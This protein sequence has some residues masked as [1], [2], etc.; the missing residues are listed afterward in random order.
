M[1]DVDP[2][3]IDGADE[4]PAF[5]KIAAGDTLLLCSDGLNREIDPSDLVTI[6]YESD[7]KHSPECIAWACAGAALQAGGQ[8]NITVVVLTI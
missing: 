6:V 4:Q 3:W 8:D 7:P 5:R 2:K 1:L